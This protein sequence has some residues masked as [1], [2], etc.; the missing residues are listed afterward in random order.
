MAMAQLDKQD[1]GRYATFTRRA[2]MLSAGMAAIGGVL[3]G[4]LY[5]LQVVDG[6]T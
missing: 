4:R 2:L 3:A 1:N 5:Q 6:Q